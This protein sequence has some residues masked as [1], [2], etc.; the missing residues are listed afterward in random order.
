MANEHT[1]LTSLFSDIADAIRSKTESTDTIIA[2]EFPAA[3][4]ALENNK[5]WV[6]IVNV[7]KGC[8]SVSID[9]GFKPTSCV[10]G[11][12][13]SR[14]YSGIASIAYDGT[15]AWLQGY[16]T[17][18]GDD[19]PTGRSVTATLSDAGV[20]FSGWSTTLCAGSNDLLMV[21]VG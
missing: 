12:F 14:F 20:T 21:C 4:Q 11:A 1:T 8:T 19:T 7:P 16:K 18:E 9:C 17:E 10:G 13:G 15:A 2:D 3:I 6:G 5:F